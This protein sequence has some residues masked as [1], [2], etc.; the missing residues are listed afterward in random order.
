MTSVAIHRPDG[1]EDVLGR[2][3]ACSRGN[4]AASRTP[5][6]ASTDGI[7][8]A[9]NR[10]SPRAVDRPIHAPAAGQGGV[11]RVDDHIRRHL[12]NVALLQRESAAC[13]AAPF[14]TYL[15]KSF[16]EGHEKP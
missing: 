6:F 2:K 13:S 8:V 7:Q 11:S 16:L 4:G 3:S 14:H 9:H 12:R 10:R 5:A 1:V 15:L